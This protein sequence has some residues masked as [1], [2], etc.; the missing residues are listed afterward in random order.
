MGKIKNLK[1]WPMSKKHE[2]NNGLQVKGKTSKI[3]DLIEKCVQFHLM[4]IFGP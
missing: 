3:Q 2:I 4:A 1:K